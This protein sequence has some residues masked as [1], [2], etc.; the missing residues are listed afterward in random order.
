MVGHR[1]L[2]QKGVDG[3][4]MA[5]AFHRV[6]WGGNGSEPFDD[7]EWELFN[8]EE[9]FS[10]AHDLSDDEEDKLEQMQAAFETEAANHKVFPIDD[11]LADRFNA[12]LRPTVLGNRTK[13]EFYEGATRLPEPS[14]PNTKDKSHTITAN[15]SNLTATVEG[16]ILA[17][18]GTTGG[19]TLYVDKEHHLVYEYNYFDT[20]RTPIRSAGPLPTGSVEVKLTSPMM[21]AVTWAVVAW[22][23]FYVDGNEV[24]QADIPK[25]VP[26][27]FGVDT[28]DVGM[29]LP[30]ADQRSIPTAL[31][32]HGRD[33]R[34]GD[35]RSG[36]IDRGAN[37]RWIGS[38]YPPLPLLLIQW[39]GRHC[40]CPSDLQ[41]GIIGSSI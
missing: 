21:I 3:E 19:Y 36:S 30:G 9:D 29:D 23:R 2:Y 14:A 1:A 17:M 11:R 5:S 27:R 37:E 18:G 4:W 6:P 38:L 13:F 12:D 22:G 39:K 20:E 40:V 15:L 25:T 31:Y 26:V 24:A 33:D 34:S 16:V 41:L 7:D 35:D 8:L 10:Q 32:V 28:Q